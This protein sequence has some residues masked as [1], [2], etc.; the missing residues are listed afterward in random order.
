MALIIV[1]G[2][3]CS[4][5]SAAAA[6]ICSALTPASQSLCIVDEPGLN[7]IRSH[8]YASES[9]SHSSEKRSCDATWHQVHGQKFVR[10][11][12]VP[13]TTLSLAEPMCHTYGC[14]LACPIRSALL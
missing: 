14:M 7:L 3:P 5:K 2:P 6:Q 13:C 12:S 1:C 8:S 11:C 9:C 4:G 10:V